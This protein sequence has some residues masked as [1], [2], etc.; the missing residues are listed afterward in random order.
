M[1]KTVEK[2]EQITYEIAK[3]A[4]DLLEVTYPEKVEF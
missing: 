3:K 2:D 1:H 4:Y